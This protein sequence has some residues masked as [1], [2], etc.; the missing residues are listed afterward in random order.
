MKIMGVKAPIFKDSSRVPDGEKRSS[1][2]GVCL[3]GS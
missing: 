1:G 3:W 2:F